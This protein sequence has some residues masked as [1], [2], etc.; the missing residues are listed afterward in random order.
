MKTIAILYVLAAACLIAA[1][2]ASVRGCRVEYPETV[3]SGNERMETEAGQPLVR[4]MAC[5]FRV[6]KTGRRVYEV[7][8]FTGT[9]WVVA[10]SAPYRTLGSAQLAVSVELL[11][12]SGQA[13]AIDALLGAG[14]RK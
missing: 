11:R 1:V 6:Q 4:E 14:V 12:I 3:S 2:A 10:G 7:Q 8:F 5:R 9:N 13:S